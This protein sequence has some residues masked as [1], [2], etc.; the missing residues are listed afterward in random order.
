MRA[1]ERE[2]MLSIKGH[3]V[4]CWALADDSRSHDDDD[5]HPCRNGEVFPSTRVK[6]VQSIFAIAFLFWLIS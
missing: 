5:G 4:P 2:Y 1:G 6:G 3:T